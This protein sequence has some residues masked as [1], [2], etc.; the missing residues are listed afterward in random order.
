MIVEGR[1][2]K[3]IEVCRGCPNDCCCNL[4]YKSPEVTG[5]FKT[6]DFTNNWNE[7]WNEN[8]RKIILFQIL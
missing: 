6:I 3:V 2:L 4:D 7:K 1:E 8:Q 5:D